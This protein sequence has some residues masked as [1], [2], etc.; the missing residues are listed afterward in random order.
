MAYRLG[1]RSSKRLAPVHSDMVRVVKRAIQITPV[2]FAVLEGLRT[3]ERHLV[4]MQQ[5]G[6]RTKK[7]RHLTGHAVD[8]GA[9]VGGEVR[10]DFG[11]YVKI[12]YAMRQAAIELDVSV[13]WGACWTVINDEDDLEA[14]I[15]RYVA[16]KK[17]QGKTPLIDGPHFHL[18]RK[19]Y[20]VE[21]QEA[22]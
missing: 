6:S 19:R 14:A 20:P 18:C 3:L 16:R 1:K 21:Q 8:L 2:D 13:V 17:Q 12:A 11:L 5:G 4:L 10:W 22:A 7:S 15:A 9:W